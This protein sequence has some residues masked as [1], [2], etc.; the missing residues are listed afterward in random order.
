[1]ASRIF[2]DG[3]SGGGLLHCNDRSPARFS[4]LR[5]VL[6]QYLPPSLLDQEF[7]RLSCGDGIALCRRLAERGELFDRVLVDAPCSSERH[8]AQQVT[9]RPGP[10]AL[11][12]VPREAWSTTR[13]QRN[14]AAQASLVQSALGC[15]APGGRLVYS[16]CSVSPLENDGVVDQLLKHAAKGRSPQ[17]RVASFD[18]PEAIKWSQLIPLEPTRHGFIALPDKT[19]YGP[20]FFALIIK[21]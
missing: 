16:T 9:A 4:R 12:P 18:D 14:A 6:S 10:D 20:L 13:S 3:G 21:E 15:L 11:P 2:P 19:H 8:V 17:I 7:V 1:M 5:R